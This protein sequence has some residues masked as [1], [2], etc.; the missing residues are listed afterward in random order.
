MIK[1]NICQE[2]SQKDSCKQTFEKLGDT[3]GLSVTVRSI[4]AFLLPLI[5]F[6]ATLGVFEKTFS[7]NLNN[8]QLQTGVGFLLALAV[9]L[10][11]ISVVWAVNK[12]IRKQ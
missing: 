8:K 6:I 1:E 5:I 10:V 12:Y 4:L 7:K 2:C 3:R 11:Y 9:T